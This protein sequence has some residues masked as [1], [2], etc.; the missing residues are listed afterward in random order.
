MSAAKRSWDVA[1]HY[2]YGKTAICNHNGTGWDLVGTA[3]TE[4]SARLMAAAP[5]LLEACKR[6]LVCMAIANWEGDDTAVAARAA[7]A[8]AIGATS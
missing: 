8:K 3:K 5:D 7:I 2:P 1:P 6:L 4:D